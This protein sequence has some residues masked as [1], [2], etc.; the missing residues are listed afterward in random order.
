VNHWPFIA[1][2]YAVGIGAPLALTIAAWIA[3]RR[4]ERP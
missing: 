4:A 3:M 1:A 2:A